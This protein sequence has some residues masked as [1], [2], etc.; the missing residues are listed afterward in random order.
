[1]FCG[2]ATHLSHAIPALALNG[3][4]GATDKLRIQFVNPTRALL[5]G[6]WP[7]SAVRRGGCRLNQNFS[8]GW[9]QPGGDSFERVRDRIGVYFARGV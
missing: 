2:M 7:V 5:D 1:M 3:S 4:L 9:P 8:L 6:V